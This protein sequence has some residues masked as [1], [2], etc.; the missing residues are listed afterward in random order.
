MMS[1]SKLPRLLVPIV[2]MFYIKYKSKDKTTILDDSLSL[3]TL[4][5]SLPPAEYRTFASG[6]SVQVYVVKDF[7]PLPLA[8]KWR[9]TMRHQWNLHSSEMPS[10]Y[11]RF[12][13]NNDGKSVDFTRNN[14]LKT[15]SLEQIHARN[16]SS[17]QLDRHNQFAYSK[18][19]LLPSHALVQEMER[20]FCSPQMMERVQSVIHNDTL[21]QFQSALSDLFVTYYGTGDFLNTHDDGVAGTWAF[22]VSL[23]DGP[24]DPTTNMTKPWQEDFGGQT[25]YE[26]P[27][28]E[29]EFRQMY[30]K[31]MQPTY[32][33]EWC[34][35]IFPSFNTALLFRT[36]P[37][38]PQHDVFPVSYKAQEER[39]FRFGLTGWYM[40]VDD[41]MD[42]YDSA[43]RDKMRGRD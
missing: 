11:W 29:S 7:L 22:V 15:R 25:R 23:M 16:V 31:Q 37:V 6:P 9:D 32:E 33:Y 14:N 21:T 30:Y 24:V 43:E 10:S 20:V 2:A 27:Y 35:S 12:A 34:K 5:N 18:W 13:T 28:D 41:A 38:G 1:I 19:E 4:F 17:Q 42:D 3:E 39:F 26:C 40:G 8:Q 36:R